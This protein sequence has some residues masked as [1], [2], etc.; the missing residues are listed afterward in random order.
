MFKNKKKNPKLAI[1]RIE[2]SKKQLE[3]M[4]TIIDEQEH[5]LETGL[6]GNAYV[7]DSKPI[8]ISFDVNL[9]EKYEVG[10]GTRYSSNFYRFV[11]V[12][13]HTYGNESMEI[14]GYELVENDAT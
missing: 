11:D 12:S 10:E 5:N 13:F 3:Q 2:L 14:L 7:D 9:S 1:V 6:D 4:L 8:K